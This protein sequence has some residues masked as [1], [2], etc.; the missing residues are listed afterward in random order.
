MTLKIERKLA[1]FP[2]IACRLLARK[3]GP[4]G[5]IVA[6]TDE[7]IRQASGLP[8]AVI[9]HLSWSL[10]WSG[11]PCGHMLAFTKGCGVDLNS[12]EGVRQN[13]RYLRH[14]TWNHILRSGQRQQFNELLAEWRRSRA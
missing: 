5:G 9:K 3:R 6:M 14:G 10:S 13:T 4:N 12:R 11:E 2:P 7:D 1:I 8:M